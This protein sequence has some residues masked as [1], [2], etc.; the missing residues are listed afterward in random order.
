M[1]GLVEN[2]LNLLDQFA[3]VAPG[4]AR[5]PTSVSILL[6]A[7]QQELQTF[8]LPSHTG[9][10]ISGRGASNQ[11]AA[12]AVVLVLATLGL[13]F[14]GLMA[15]AGFTVLAHRRQRALGMLACLGATDRHLRLVLLA[16]GA[17]VGAT[18][19]ISGTV[20]GLAGWFAFAPAVQSASNHRVDRWSL[21]WWAHRHPPWS[22]PS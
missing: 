5:P 9:L 4:Q 15:V 1:V 16:N 14:V 12:A 11:A 22:S 19:A 10:D 2:P 17:A 6:N 3:L 20:I 21:P 18:A 7:G 13:L 8:R